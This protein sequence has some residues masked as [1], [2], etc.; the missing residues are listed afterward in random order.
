VLAAVS[1]QWN[2]V[3]TT[4]EKASALPP[5]LEKYTAVREHEG[6]IPRVLE[7]MLDDI[8]DT[9]V[10][11]YDEEEL[12]LRREVAFHEAI[13]EEHGHRDRAQAKAD[14]ILKALEHTDDVVT[15][16]DDRSD[17]AASHRSVNADT[18]H[19]NWCGTAG[20]PHSPGAAYG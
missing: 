2:Q 9:L 1:P 6:A 15:L 14:V 10:T 16:A 7:D 4:L 19:R 11:E 17:H 12:P 18:A 13:I 20:L 3:K 8:L 5:L